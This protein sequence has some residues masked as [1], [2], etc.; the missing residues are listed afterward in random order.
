MRSSP[1]VHAMWAC[2]FVFVL[3][4]LAFMIL[5]PEIK[6]AGVISQYH[7]S[8]RQ[9]AM[10]DHHHKRIVHVPWARLLSSLVPSPNEPYEFRIPFKMYEGVPMVSLHIS[11]QRRPFIAVADTGS[12][13]LNLSS[14]SCQWC[15]KGNGAYKSTPA[16][17]AAPSKMLTYGTQH[18]EV[19][20]VHDRIR[21]HSDSDEI[22]VPVHV[23]VKRS[24]AQSNHN[25]MGLLTNHKLRR[26]KHGLLNHLLGPQNH[27]FLEF[28]R[29]RGHVSGVDARYTEGMRPHAIAKCTRV[30]STMGFYIVRVSGIWCGN[31]QI[32]STA[33]YAIIDSGS[34]MT[35]LSPQTY[36]ACLPHFVRRAPLVIEF[37]AQPLVVEPRNYIWHNSK[38]YMVDDD[39]GVLR[40][41]TDYIILGAYCMQGYSFLF[42]EDEIL[43][44]KTASA[45]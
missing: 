28:D 8:R 6:R 37:D 2:L 16:L 5:Y 30:H 33:R 11:T 34:N 19:K 3:F 15:N 35:S 25:V 13:H 45:F 27:L 26:N 10:V 7:E 23:T 39:L 14:S 4:G 43:I 24:K 22:V 12:M 20:K 44:F 9:R 18:D 40:G 36:R 38:D 17:E 42:S 1:T 21:L 31:A 32:P 41:N 29:G